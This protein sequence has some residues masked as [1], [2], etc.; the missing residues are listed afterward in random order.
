MGKVTLTYY[1]RCKGK[2]GHETLCNIKFKGDD[3]VTLWIG[4]MGSVVLSIK[5]GERY[6]RQKYKTVTH[7][8]TVKCESFKI[9]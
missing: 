1:Y 3:D 4:N 6:M 8:K 9:E 5:E 7:Y 2:Y